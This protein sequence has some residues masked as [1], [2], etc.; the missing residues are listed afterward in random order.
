MDIKLIELDQIDFNAVRKKWLDDPQI[1]KFISYHD[2]V[3]NDPVKPVYKKYFEIYNEDKLVGDIKVFTEEKDQDRKQAQILMV[4]GE[5]RSKGIGTLA[6]SMLLN[7]LRGVFDSVYCH[8]N[9][10]NI[11]SIKMLKNC[12][13]LIDDFT[14]N[15][16]I[17]IR[18]LG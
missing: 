4:V 6:L 7:K 18:K 14:E 17:L 9:R 13:F 12:G 1:K 16:V 3:K 10:Y 5:N 15:D 2:Q 11:P 8:V